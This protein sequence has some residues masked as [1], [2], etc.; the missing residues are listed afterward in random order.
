MGQTGAT[1]LETIAA[2]PQLRTPDDGRVIT[3]VRDGG[4]KVT[5]FTI[6]LWS[7]KGMPFEKLPNKRTEGGRG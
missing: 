4:K 5:G 2:A 6:Q 7:I 3:F 1:L